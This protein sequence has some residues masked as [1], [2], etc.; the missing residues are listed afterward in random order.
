VKELLRAS[1]IDVN[2]RDGDDRTAL[3]V[4]KWKNNPVIIKLLEQGPTGSMIKSAH[5]R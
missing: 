3:D 4:A 5:K 2:A 1:G